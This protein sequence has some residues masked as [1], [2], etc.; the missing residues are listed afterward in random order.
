MEEVDEPAEP[1]EVVEEAP[2]EPA[3]PGWANGEWGEFAAIEQTGAGDTIITLPEGA[4]GGLVTATHNG[5]SNF[6][7]SVLDESNGSTGELLVNTIGAYT[8]TTA[9]GLNALGEGARLQVTADG[10][11]SI[12]INPMG[13]APALAASGA[14]DAVFLYDGGAGALAVTHDGTSNFVVIED[15]ASAFHMG[16]LIND[17][18][19]YAGTVPLAAG[20]SVIA[21]TAD[22]NWTLAV[23]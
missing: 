15:T 23:Q 3:A 17:I 21:V 19:S 8:G 10:E 12:T 1:E 5:G 4:S 20:P 22:G 14:G 13:A 7:I 11:W 18:G 2:A 16:L 6:A 9:W